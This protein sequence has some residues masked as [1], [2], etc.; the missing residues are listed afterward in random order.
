MRRNGD[1]NMKKLALIL[2]SL[3]LLLVP[4]VLAA[5]SIIIITPQISDAQNTPATFEI[6]TT[7]ASDPTYD[8]HVLLVMTTACYNGLTDV[9]VNWTGGSVTFAKSDF[10]LLDNTPPPPQKIPSDTISEVQ[11]N[12]AALADH[13]G[14]SGDSSVYWA[15]K[16]FMSG[17]LHQTPQQFTVTLHSTK[18]KMTVY[19]IGKTSLTADKFDRWVPPTNPGLVVPELVPIALASASFAAF[20]LYATKRKRD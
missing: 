16:P 17:P 15:M 12:R 1:I 6:S 2:V 14:L 3:C 10:A 4:S 5:N 9:E 11:Y 20:A 13:L 18:P 8:P 19:A 7:P